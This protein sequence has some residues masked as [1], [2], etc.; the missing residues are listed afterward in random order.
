VTGRWIRPSSWSTRRQATIALILIAA[1]SFALVGGVA[2]V[3]AHRVARGAALAEGL[4]TAR[5]TG[6]VLLAP[7]LPAVIAGD[8]GATAN[9]VA[10]IDRRRAEGTL[11]RV[12][13]WR[14]DGTVI[15]SDNAAII[16]TRFALRPQETAVIDDRQ[17]F[18]EISPLTDAADA[19]VRAG[20]R[21]LVEAYIPLELGGS[22]V[23]LEMYFSEARVRAAEAEERARLVAFS[24]AG[25]L[26][27]AFAQLPV[28]IWLM[29]R[30][31]RAQHDRDRMRETALVSSERERRLLARSL[32]DGVVQ[33][34]AGAAY[35]LGS[36][37][38]TDPL[39]PDT[40]RAM[41]LV[42]L[43]LQHAV[44]DLRGMLIEL[45]PDEVTNAN[46]KEL[47]TAAAARACPRQR[48]SVSVTLD[49]PLP[50]EVLAFLYRAAR[51]C[52]INVAKH[53]RAKTVDLDITSGPAGVRLVVRDDGIGIQDSLPRVE[54]HLG[55]TLLRTTAAELGGALEARGTDGGTTVTIDLPAQSH[56]LAS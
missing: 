39:P 47:V 28:S 13:V 20:T 53:A 44:D 41:D 14:R 24:L 2:L 31:S 11:L 46:L 21:G 49:R 32:H 40:V 6:R 18:A 52:A 19:D 48:V 55:L 22:T 56:V 50:P 38:P 51:E 15:W 45:H 12:K 23:A 26:V 25:L 54:G 16:G 17:A 42:S 5:G 8:R 36:R 1:V 9:L 30:I 35:A 3:V 7:V 4:R 43:T 27:L 29:R 33:E 37:E 34:L 10:D